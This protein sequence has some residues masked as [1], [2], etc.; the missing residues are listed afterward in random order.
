MAQS[1]VARWPG[2]GQAQ[3]SARSGSPG[4]DSQGAQA[5][6]TRSLVAVAGAT[7][8]VPATH[9]R[10]ATHTGGEPAAKNPGSHATGAIGASGAA[11]GPAH[12]PT[13]IRTI[14]DRVLGTPDCRR[15]R[16]TPRAHA[17]TLPSSAAGAA[18]AV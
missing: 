4:Q 11:T 5:S 14:A 8:C 2:L 10:I 9:A 7:C 18:A 12:A 1:S 15:G 16:S 13:K 3:V 6:H 17:A